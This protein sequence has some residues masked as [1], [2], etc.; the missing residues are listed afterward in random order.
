LKLINHPVEIADAG[1]VD[2]V[3]IAEADADLAEAYMYETLLKPNSL[4]TTKNNAA[5]GKS[6]NRLPLY[7]KYRKPAVLIGKYNF[8]E[9]LNLTSN[10]S[11]KR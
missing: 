8:I 7:A 2:P 4:A 10:G 9:Q 1:L 5:L 3:E 6:Q 11:Q